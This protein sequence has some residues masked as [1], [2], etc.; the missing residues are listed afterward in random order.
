MAAHDQSVQ[1]QSVQNQSVQNQSRQR[2]GQFGL[3]PVK[4]RSQLGE[5]DDAAT[6]CSSDGA[7]TAPVGGGDGVIEAVM[8]G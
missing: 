5:G 7:T 3:K 4:Q 2:V 6:L 1:N 8:E